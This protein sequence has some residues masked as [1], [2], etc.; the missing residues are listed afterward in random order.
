V[1]ERGKEFQPQPC[2]NGDIRAIL[3]LKQAVA[4]G[5]HWY[6]AL[7]EAIGLWKKAEEDYDGRHY[8]YLV[9]EE[10]FDWL[11]L[12]ERLCLEIEG[13]I[14]EQE[15]I[16][17]LFFAKPPLEL[18]AEK[19]RRFIGDVKYRAYLNYWYGV[20]VEEML[21]LAVEEEVRKE[22]HF[23]AQYSE[24]Q[25]QRE[26]YGRIYGADMNTLLQGVRQ[27]R[28]YREQDSVTLGEMKEFAYW[29]FRYRLKHCD[30][31]RV[32][33]DTK[34]ALAYLQRQWVTKGRSGRAA[35]SGPPVAVEANV[36][37]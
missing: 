15:K 17:L 6:I 28:G 29:R 36:E 20:V 13:V 7:L 31:T 35:D 11:L 16:D 2:A 32:A 37:L 33:S 27:E 8:C 30:E 34:K 10:A 9:A 1:E 21:V 26:V 5:K 14:P 4:E 19:F 22:N 18:S 3:H 25:V 23:I 12:A 24:E